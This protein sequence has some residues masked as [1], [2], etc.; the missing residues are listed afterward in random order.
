MKIKTTIELESQLIDDMV[1]TA[2]EGGSTY[3]MAAAKPKD[4]DFR[5]CEYAHAVPM[6][7]GTLLISH[8]GINKGDPDKMVSR[9]TQH[10]LKDGMQLLADQCPKHFSNILEENWDADTADALV[11]LAVFGEVVFG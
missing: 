10:N 4:G 11:Q 7:G 3:W 1:C 5:G 8:E 2:L 9:L 6:A